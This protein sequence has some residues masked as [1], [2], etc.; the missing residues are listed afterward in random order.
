MEPEEKVEA[1]SKSSNKTAIIV[2]VV[3][4]LLGV[5][6]FFFR[7]TV[8]TPAGVSVDKNLDGSATYTTEE[9]TVTIGVNSYP[10]NWPSD[11]PKYSNGQIQYSGTS[12]PQTGQAGS[13]VVFITTD[14]VQKVVDFYK[15]ELTSTGWK[16]EQTATIGQMMVISATKGSTAFGAQIVKMD[17]GQTS[18]TVG[19]GN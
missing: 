1:S 13:A 8:M 16:I 10:D 9:G 2:V 11:V 15:R 17:D 6:W 3:L 18:V 4:V 7:G 19:I 5:V 12:N 14:D